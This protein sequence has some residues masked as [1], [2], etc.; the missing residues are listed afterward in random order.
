[1]AIRELHRF[2]ADYEKQSGETYVPAVTA[3]KRDEKIAVIGSGPAGLTA[4]YY[5][6]LERLYGHHF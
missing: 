6:D 5:S 2:L 3:E 4:A 1:L